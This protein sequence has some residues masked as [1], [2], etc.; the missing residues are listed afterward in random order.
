MVMQDITLYDANGAAIGTYATIQKALDASLDGYAVELGSGDYDVTGASLLILHSVTIRGANAGTPGAGIRGDESVLTGDADTTI[1]QIADAAS[2]TFNGLKIVG[3][4]LLVSGATGQA[5]SFANNVLDITGTHANVIYM[6]NSGGYTFGFTD[7][8]VTQSGGS[9]FIDAFEYGTVT[10]TGNSFTGADGY[11]N[12]N[13]GVDRPLILNINGAGVVSDNV[14]TNID[15]G[16]LVA[17]ASGPLTIS[18]NEFSDLHRDPGAGKAAGVVFFTP[19]YA[20][21]ITIE[22]NR[23]ADAD[24]GIRTSGVPGSSTNGSDIVIDDNDFD[25]VDAPVFQPESVTGTLHATDSTVDDQQVADIYAAGGDADTFSSGDDLAATN[26]HYDSATTT[27]QI[28]VGDDTTALSGYDSVSDSQGQTFLLVKGTGGYASIQAAVDAASGGES[29]LIAPGTYT[30]SHTT[31]SGAAGLY[32]NTADLSFYGYSTANGALVTSGADAQANGPTIIASA[33][34]NFGAS[35]WVDAGGTNASFTGV[36]FQA[37]PETGNKVLEI[38]A[39]GTSLTNSFVDAYNADGYTYAIALYFNDVGDAGTDSISSFTV[40][41]NV[42]NEGI[43]LSNGVGD[44]ENGDGSTLLI[45]NNT[46]IGTFDENGEGRYDGIAL[47]GKEVGTSAAGYRLESNEYPTI[48]DN[49]FGD[50]TTPFV[51]RASDM[52]ASLVPDRAQVEALLASNTVARYVYVL[53]PTGELRFASQE[54]T[55]GQTL[56]RLAVVNDIDTLNLGLDAAPDNVFYTGGARDYIHTGDTL[57][58]QTGAATDDSTILVDNLHVLALAGSTDLNLTLGTTLVDDTPI[59]NGG[60][61]NI[62]LD[63]YATGLGV[64]VDVT[65]NDIGNTLIG[66]S[67]ANRLSGGGGD[68]DLNGRGGDDT[69]DGGA[70]IDEAVYAGATTIVATGTGWTVIGDGGTDTLTNVEKVDDSALGRVLLV[71]S[72]GFATIQ[73]A[74]TAASDGDTI[75]VATGTY[76]ENLV[77][78]KAVTILGIKAGVSGTDAGRGA[79]TGNDETTIIGD[80]DITASGKVVLD[81]LRFVNTS[82]TTGGNPDSG[83]TLGIGNGNG[84]VVTNSI[85][86]SEVA[87]GAVSDGDRAIFLSPAAIGT[88]SITDNYIGGASQ[89][90]FSTASWSRAL[91]F[92]GGGVDLVFTGNTVEYA[93]SGLNL[94]MGGTSDAMISG[95]VFKTMTTAISLGVDFDGV[96]FADNDFVAVGTEFNFRNLADPVNF[97]GDVAADEVTLIGNDLF[98]VTGGTGADALKGTAFADYLDGNNS[99]TLNTTDADT[100]E[101]RGGN[102]QLFGRGGNDTLD[103]GA[104]NDTLTGGAG[105]DTLIGGTGTDTAVFSGTASQYAV[106]GTK[107]AGGRYTAFSGIAG[108]DGTDTLSSIETLTFTGGGA[109]SLNDRVQVTDSNGKL[110]GTYG[111]IQAAIDAAP[112]DATINLA[113]GSYA[114]NI[115]IN[116]DGLTIQGAGA[117]LTGN[118]LTT[119]GIAVGALY[120][121]L[122]TPGNGIGNSSGTGITVNAD[123]VTING[124][125]VQGFYDAT[126]LGDGTDALTLNDVDYLSNLNSIRKETGASVSGL[127]INDGSIGDGYVGLLIFK[128]V[129]P[130]QAATGNLSNVRIDGTDFTDLARK[131]IYTETLSNAR[132]TDITMANVGQLGAT[133]GLDGPPGTSGAGINLNLKNGVYSNIEIDHFTLTDVGVSNG[134]GSPHAGGGAI[135]I[136]ARD[137]GGTYGP[138]PGSFTGAIAIHDGSISGT[139]SSGIVV[140]EPGRANADPDVT[141]TA[142][143]VDG[144]QFSSTFGTVANEANGTTLTFNGSALADVITA[145]GNSDGGIVLNGLAGADTLTGGKGADTLNGGTEAD[146]L[147]GLDGSDALNGGDGADTLD[148]GAGIDTMAGGAGNDTYFVDNSGDII[149]EN[150]GEG[151]DLVYASA[152]YALGSSVD[153]LTL[154]GTLAINGTGNGLA[155]ILTGNG[156]ANTLDGGGGDDRLIGGG[157]GGADTL[158]GG[159][160]EDVADYSASTAGVTVDLA[161]GTGLGGDAQGDTLNGVE[162][163]TGSALGDTLLGNDDANLLSGGAGADMLDGRGGIDTMIGGAGNDTYIVDTSSDAVVELAGDGVDTVESSVSYTLGANVDNLT[164]TGSA[165]TGAGNLLDNAITGNTANN[166]LSGNNGNDTLDGGAGNDTLVGGVGDDIYVVDTTGDLINEQANEGT[167]TVRTTLNTYTLA[168]NLENLTFAGLTGAFT[169]TGNAVANVITGGAGADKLD[170]KAGADTLIGLGGDDAYVVDNANDAV[171][172]AAGGGIDIVTASVSYTLS[173]NVDN[174]TLAT[175]AA[176]GTGNAIANRIVGNA[177]A[178]TL[179]GEGGDDYLDGGDGTDTMI[180]GSGDDT[181]VARETSDMVT[182]LFDDGTDLVLSNAATYTLSA[183]VENLTLASTKAITGIGNAQD[184]V[185]TGNSSA[186]TLRGEGGDDYLDGGKG[187]DK[188]FGGVGDDTFVVDATG[189]VVTENVGEGTD[190]VRTAL[191]AYTIGAN[192][193]NLTYIG[194]SSFT[195]TG[196]AVANTITGGNGN[197]TLD[198]RGGA[199]T[200]IGGLGN[201][202]YFV[203]D[204]GDVIVDTGGID[205]VKTVFATATLADGLENLT[206]VGVGN[207]TGTGNAANNTITGGVGNDRLNG[208]AGNDTLVGGAGDDTYVVDSTA[209]LVSEGISGGIDTVETAASAYTLGANVE[210]LTYTGSGAFTGTGN[211]LANVIRGGAGNDLLDGMAGSDTLIGFGGD[212]IYVVDSASDIVTEQAGAGSGIDTVRSTATSYTLGANI[213][214][215]VLLGSSGINATGNALDN[216]LTGNTGNNKLDGGAGDDTMAGGKGNDTYVVD[217]TGDVVSESSGSTYGVDTIETALVSYTL[218]GNVENLTYT[219]TQ[220]FTGTGTS[221]NN[222]ITGGSGN[223]S[224]DGGDGMDIMIGGLGNDTYYVS[225]VEDVVTEAANDGTDLV[226]SRADNFLLSANVEDLRIIDNGRNATGNALDNSMTGNALA[227]VLDG[228][229]GADELRGGSGNDTFVLRLGQIV[230]GD[231]VADFTG[232]G[233]AVGDQLRLAGFGNNAVLSQ[234]G[235]SDFY[236]A[237]GSAGSATFQISG[238]YNLNTAAGSNDFIFGL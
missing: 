140:G 223:D 41:G 6:G 92:N 96:S 54:T 233:V 191:A 76:T 185:I 60:V 97:D 119:N 32:V 74:I 58:V 137:D 90:A 152:T 65:G 207:F 63:D 158:M 174:L 143:T 153:N 103:G 95:N 183:N 20:A 71:G 177:A 157:G 197:D 19:A 22:D 8:K 28:K 214:N 156:A 111:T 130:G 190:T 51:L 203:D 38:W 234:V 39:D 193:E 37:G 57:V 168:A 219:G 15:I 62:I 150:A 184:N 13:N 11:F 216:V 162:D 44:A 104:E 79:S 105:N 237:T 48:T 182:E 93:R 204:A 225:R 113:P 82:A 9:D 169:G 35:H 86:W 88:V 25:D 40:S 167:D 122:T 226:L 127:T 180:G 73:A 210:D 49:D 133:A 77:I 16:V 45:T 135:V 236:T 12:P 164:L 118:L 36:H 14:F 5:I 46:F 200:L 31:A 69:L 189:D 206:F 110:V 123:R 222:T 115:V 238:V 81:G 42:F 17:N 84:H 116:K 155:N 50:G 7:N 30:E 186:N 87:S 171:I 18:G 23:F 117:T 52:D 26:F 196:N 166:I 4:S 72:S 175:G 120:E 124:L 89:G 146:S 224:I 27:W 136:T 232:A 199:D 209:D 59:A 205:T 235:N 128:T 134:A 98:V 56:D 24:A 144:E 221:A 159:S 173:A 227:N 91:Y 114:E 218:K 99:N 172:E 149:G 198:G 176:N 142:V 67:G 33:E 107:D 21:T 75:M 195:G 106:T 129:T 85:F 138:A 126:L 2:V 194:A 179:R 188:L 163:V 83:A 161:S 109:I 55:G 230:V 213:E 70:G 229:A 212:D 94:D 112:T 187:S 29:I 145:S 178:N 160:G 10:V 34:N 132:I 43:A 228:G 154:T 231:R 170:G 108:P 53:T 1:F 181:Y 147:Y 192:I 165:L 139:L 201:D 68:D 102:D 202:T 101:G 220:N 141:V 148:G 47:I 208:A 78:D 121:Y 66:N 215:I 64:N 217:S 211:A 61:Q 3:D 151:V 125:D 80:S 131:G 100:L